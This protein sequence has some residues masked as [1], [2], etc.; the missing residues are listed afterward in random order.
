MLLIYWCCL[1]KYVWCFAHGFM[2]C[3]AHFKP[4]TSQQTSLPGSLC[5]DCPQHP[6]AHAAKLMP[7]SSHFK[8]TNMSAHKS[9]DCLKG[10]STGN[11]WVFHIFFKGFPASFRRKANLVNKGTKLTQKP[12]NHILLP[13]KKLP[14]HVFAP[15]VLNCSGLQSPSNSPESLV[16]FWAAKHARFLGTLRLT[17]FSWL[18]KINLKMSL[19]D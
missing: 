19:N 2:I 17:G 6:H 4:S 18:P 3:W 5:C 14:W 1:V 9:L 12:L 16:P 11:P 8:K 10:K 15:G 7:H 13:P